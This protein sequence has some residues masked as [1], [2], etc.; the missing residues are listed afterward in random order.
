MDNCL[1]CLEEITTDEYIKFQSP[2]WIQ[3][4]VLK[5]VEKYFWTMEALNPC[6]G[7]GHFYAGSS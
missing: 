3:L 1:L 6:V 7:I 2:K 5:I 4:N